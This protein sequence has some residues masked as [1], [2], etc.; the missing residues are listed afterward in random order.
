MDA[1]S[2]P[3]APLETEWPRLSCVRP[4]DAALVS[5]LMTLAVSR[6]LAPWPV[7][8]T[9]EMGIMRKRGVLATR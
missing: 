4:E 1:I 2:D 5:R 3:F 6:W 7:P 9:P 8:F